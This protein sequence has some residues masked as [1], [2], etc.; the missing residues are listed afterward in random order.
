MMVASIKGPD[1]PWKGNAFSLQAGPVTVDAEREQDGKAVQ[2]AP[3]SY[4][5]LGA[6][7]PPCE[8]ERASIADMA[9]QQYLEEG[10]LVSNS[11][12]GACLPL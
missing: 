6:A 10:R 11:E 3:Y 8:A 9:M 4:L 7:R 1:P 12:F 5:T 2:A